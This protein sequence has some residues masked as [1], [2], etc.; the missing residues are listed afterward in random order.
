MDVSWSAVVQHEY[1][2]AP[3][4]ASVGV[5]QEQGGGK[6]EEAGQGPPTILLQACYS[7]VCH[8]LAAGACVCVDLISLP[9][10]PEMIDSPYAHRTYPHPYNTNN[11]HSALGRPRRR[12]QRPLLPI[13]CAGRPPPARRAAG[14]GA[15]ARG[16]GHGRNGA[17]LPPSAQSHTQTLSHTYTHTYYK[18]SWPSPPSTRPSRWATTTAPSPS[19]ASP[20]P[21]PT[22]AAPP[23]AGGR[24][25]GDSGRR[26]ARAAARTGG[27]MPQGWGCPRRA[28]PWFGTCTGTTGW[29]P[30]ATRVWLWSAVVVV[31]RR[32]RGGSARCCTPAERRGTSSWSSSGGKWRVFFF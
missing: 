20:P 9:R 23:A 30:A 15:G 10:I 13:L 5:L 11:N 22:P 6:G 19:S 21:T 26:S 3:E 17:S 18:P 16:P 14:G 2:L 8:L 24:G 29:G 12:E 32:G 1:H 28:P 31:G 4:A 25:R 27:A 7:D